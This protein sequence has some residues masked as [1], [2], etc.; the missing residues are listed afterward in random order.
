[1]KLLGTWQTH[2]QK[3]VSLTLVF[4]LSISQTLGQNPPPQGQAPQGTGGPHA[5]ADFSIAA[6]A[7]QVLAAAIHAGATQA[8]AMAAK[9]AFINTA[10]R[11]G[12]TETTP[13]RGSV[14][15]TALSGGLSGVVFVGSD[16]SVLLA[17]AQ[18]PPSGARAAAGVTVNVGSISVKTDSTGA[19]NL[20]KI[21]TGLG[22][23]HVA[24]AEGQSGDFPVTIFGGVTAILGPPKVTRAAALATVMN[25]LVSQGTNSQA[26]IVIGPQEPLPPGTMVAPI[27]G[28][29]NGQPNPAVDYTARTEQWFIYADPDA[30]IRYAKPVEF[31]FVD[32]VSGALTKMD[33]MSWPLI[34]GLSYYGKHSV[35]VKSPDLMAGPQLAPKAAAN[36]ASARTFAASF[37]D[38]R[39]RIAIHRL[40]MTGHARPRLLRVSL[41][42][43]LS[44]PHALNLLPP[45]PMGQ[46][47]VPG[48][49][50]QTYAL[51]IEGEDESSSDADMATAEH[52]I[53]N[54]GIPPAGDIQ[55]ST[56]ADTTSSSK[57]GARGEDIAAKFQKVCSEAG[58]NDT[59]FL[60]ITAHGRGPNVDGV[61]IGTNAIDKDGTE[62]QT[63]LL[64]SGSFDFS[65]CRPCNI[66]IIIDACYSAVMAS[67]LN[68]K[69]KKLP[70]PPNYTIIA[71]AD[72]THG[73][74]YYESW[75]LS[76]KTGGVFT[77]RFRTAFDSQSASSPG[78]NV[79]LN[80]VFDAAKEDMSNTWSYKNRIANQNPQIFVRT[81]RCPCQ[82]PTQNTCNNGQPGTPNTPQPNPGS[83]TPGS[84]NCQPVTPT[85]PPPPTTNQNSGNT[86]PQPPKTPQTPPSP[87]PQTPAEV[88]P[89]CIIYLQAVIELRNELAQAQAQLAAQNASIANNQV[90]QRAAQAKIAALQA[91]LAGQQGTGGSGYDPETGLTTESVTQADGTVLTTVKDANG[92]ILQQSVRNRSDLAGIQR[93]LSA[94]QGQLASLKTEGAALAKERDRLAARV[95][96]LTARLQDAIQQ[97]ADCLE[98]KCSHLIG[99]RLNTIAE[100]FG[101]DPLTGKPVPPKAT[102]NATG[103]SSSNATNA[104]ESAAGNAVNK[105][106]ESKVSTP[107][108]QGGAGAGNVRPSNAVLPGGGEPGSSNNNGGDNNGENNNGADNAAN[109]GNAGDNPPPPP[110][111]NPTP[112]AEERPKNFRHAQPATDST[113][114]TQP[115]QYTVTVCEG[116]NDYVFRASGGEVDATNVK[117]T[118]FSPSQ[119]PDATGVGFGNGIRISGNHVGASTIEGDFVRFDGTLAAHVKILV[120]VIDCGHHTAVVPGGNPPAANPNPPIVAGGGNA[121]PNPPGGEDS[122]PPG[123]ENENPPG[124]NTGGDFMDVLGGLEEFNSS[125]FG[126]SPAAPT[127]QNIVI[128]ININTGGAT[129]ST[130]APASTSGSLRVSP[131][132][133]ATAH[134]QST[135]RARGRFKLVTYHS[136]SPSRAPSL[137]QLLSDRSSSKFSSALPSAE[138]L[139]F[140]IVASGNLG[141]NALEFRVHDPTGRLK[142]NI[143]LPQG[144]VLEPL[145]VGARNPV[146]AV[147]G[148]NILSK[149]LTAYC[150][151]M[152]KLPP[153]PG[154]LYRLAPAAVQQKYKPIRAVLQA[155]SQLAAAGKFHS[156]SD[157]AAY[158]DFIR[159]HALWAQLENWTEQKFTQ[160][161]L[162]RT[163][164][165]A[166]HL[167][168]RWTKEMTDALQAAAPGRW[169]DI[170]MVL[171]EAHKLRG[172]TGV[173]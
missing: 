93:D 11:A 141:T 107:P 3:L 97:L 86:T 26:T 130:D 21:P 67:H 156:D 148:K 23:L 52:L 64:G 69:L 70:C 35:N 34:N 131:Q 162:E 24:T 63:E 149:Q 118:S 6:V 54:G 59:V 32:A 119:M 36:A 77:N 13:T 108:M 152:A 20:Q 45:L 112:A 17:R 81:P 27:Y 61:R 83:T 120:T 87:A 159:Q 124:G 100:Q 133:I 113:G 1:M 68:D 150:L 37:R 125:Y 161:F 99:Q 104:A 39:Y 15:P 40:K 47:Q 62:I 8:Q 167:N 42:V 134:N 90:A 57:Q 101:L 110:P 154:Q 115:N 106:N 165:N 50:G 171:D 18:T 46:S 48:S 151:D 80:Q 95:Q 56:P 73:A 89:E 5:S 72:A 16:N 123:G 140:S 94:A 43:P 135:A 138:S 31:F 103:S 170:T 84:T 153:E 30:T 51:L 98:K 71:S 33:E 157:P 74:A 155:G 65:N 160:V 22:V 55:R 168:V 82:P 169:R 91:A 60:Y 88:C 146:N 19:F 121:N 143:A 136:G 111:P 85:N 145:K 166:E 53:G 139:A 109:N 10:T 102:G 128:T 28:D 163:M 137:E 76:G 29:K 58:P 116:T 129:P 126:N 158:A 12:L 38:A 164:K 79:D 25:A 14:P 147:S 127:V 132:R 2:A 75:Q 78:G 9:N 172:T 7:D 142:G 44:R 92:N 114:I 66:I 4:L 41:P 117:S 49:G 144:M 105:A 96:V 173:L 122:N